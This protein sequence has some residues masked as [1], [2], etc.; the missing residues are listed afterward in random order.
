MGRETQAQ[1][2]EMVSPKFHE[3]RQGPGLPLDALPSVAPLPAPPSVAAQA[4]PVFVGLWS[5]PPE[6]VSF[7]VC[8]YPQHAELAGTDI[9]QR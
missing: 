9:C 1:G 3:E 5:S 7:G 8:K 4:L 6:F 2:E